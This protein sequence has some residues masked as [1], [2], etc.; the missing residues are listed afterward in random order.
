MNSNNSTVQAIVAI[1]CIIFVFNSTINAE[2]YSDK[3]LYEEL[4]DEAELKFPPTRPDLYYY[5]FRPLEVGGIYSNNLGFGGGFQLCEW[6]F[7]PFANRLC[8]GTSIGSALFYGQES[9]DSLKAINILPDVEGVK[10][11]KTFARISL[12]PLRLTYIF[13]KRPGRITYSKQY[14]DDL[15]GNIGFFINPID[16]HHF[17]YSKYHYDTSDISYTSEMKVIPFGTFGIDIC[18][19]NPI[20]SLEASIMH[21][22]FPEKFSNQYFYYQ[23]QLSV[24][25][26]NIGF[27]MDNPN[28]LVCFIKGNQP[29]K[30]EA[31]RK[32]K[33]KKWVAA[34]YERKSQGCDLVIESIEFDDKNSLFPNNAV[35]AFEKSTLTVLVKNHGPG[36][37]FDV[38]LVTSCDNQNLSLNKSINSIGNLLPNEEEIISIELSGGSDLKDDEVLFTIEAKERRG[39]D[40]QKK[41]MNTETRRYS[42]PFFEISEVNLN[43]SQ[44]GFA[45][46]NGN[47]IL[48]TGEVGELNI[49]VLNK[50]E[51]T[52]LGVNADL[53]VPFGTKADQLQKNIGNIPPGTYALIKYKV[54]LPLDYEDIYLNF[55]LNLKDV[56]PIETV[57]L[58]SFI[59]TGLLVPDIRLSID[60][61]GDFFN[62]GNFPVTITITNKGNA[63]VRDFRLPINT[64]SGVQIEPSIITL[65]SL[66][67]N[68]Q[69]LYAGKVK[70]VR[71][72]S[73]PS[74][75]FIGT[76]ATDN[77][78]TYPVECS[79][80]VKLRKPELQV[81]TY[82]PSGSSLLLGAPFEILIRP[83][84][85]GTLDAENVVLQVSVSDKFYSPKFEKNI[86]ILP[87]MTG[88]A[89][90]FS[91]PRVPRGIS[92][93]NLQITITVN[94]KDFAK[95]DTVVIIPLVQDTIQ[96][97]QIISEEE[98]PPI[99]FGELGFIKTINDT[100]K[101]LEAEGF[102]TFSENI[103]EKQMKE[104]AILDARRNLTDKVAVRITSQ[105]IANNSQLVS[106]QVRQNVSNEILNFKLIECKREQTEGGDMYRAKIRGDVMRSVKVR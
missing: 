91:F 77:L 6:Y 40:A 38:K 73:S 22:S 3:S 19:T 67:K 25:I 13:S 10:D 16:I 63:D 42:A 58:P 84:N 93:K 35:D 41:I 57:K 97:T 9:F 5:G 100:L 24:D 64:P 90:K 104:F 7:I 53:S 43:D 75:D 61:Y 105:N 82:L 26:L 34:E 56:R 28:S 21:T 55:T 46:G 18:F 78:G 8:V 36:D 1:L 80:P 30:K 47:G 65:N 23:F 17:D 68:S 72:Y 99:G 74:L 14:E 81:E 45:Q 89:E 32:E 106:D 37:A 60:S 31:K 20:F 85:I 54:E 76:A 33:I 66:T 29:H 59:P 44:S 95:L 39:Y 27:E 98:L 94:Q 12:M 11:I 70:I 88:A 83:I 96:I 50:G 86:G 103:P 79:Y 15:I 71:T 101:G 51:G 4:S 52:G 62:G 48:E 92:S 87:T 102:F 49:Q 69:Q 2:E